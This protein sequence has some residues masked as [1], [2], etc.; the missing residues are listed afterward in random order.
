ML[1]PTEKDLIKD[2]AFLN[3]RPPGIMTL[4]FFFS[5]KMSGSFCA[6]KAGE[7]ISVK[8]QKKSI[9]LEVLNMYLF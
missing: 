7:N 6:E 9:N 4:H 5:E 3:A 2:V 8:S 1:C